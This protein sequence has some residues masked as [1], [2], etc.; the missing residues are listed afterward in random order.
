[1]KNKVAVLTS[2]TGIAL[3]LCA[4]LW[5]MQ[6][7]RQGI[8][9][10]AVL[11]LSLTAAAAGLL[12][13]LY[14]AQKERLSTVSH[15]HQ[16]ETAALE[17]QSKQALAELKAQTQR[18]ME[19][20]RSSLSHSL[21]M[22]VSIIQGYA[23]LLSSG[24]VKDEEAKQEYLKKICQRSQ[25]MTEAISRQ[26]STADTLANSSLSYSELDLISLAQQAVGDLQTAA[27]EQG[28]KIQVISPE[29]HLPMQGD[30]YLLNRVLFNLLENSLKYMGRP[31]S[32][33]IR[34]LRQKANV[35][36]LVQDDGI[37]LSSQETAHIFEP[38]YQGSNRSGGKGYGLC[39]VQRAIEGHGG[40]VCAQSAPGRGMG[41]TMTLP[42]APPTA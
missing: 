11:G 42:L 21:R 34:I 40:T 12:A 17:Q 20:F 3:L 19:S 26:F 25:Y 10:A 2:L 23:E 5:L 33:T 14:A 28:V 36:I 30:S 22:P 39:L 37:G 38:Y 9:P 1:M 32:I 41:I 27:A 29:E 31:G 15:L 6:L 24:V 8:T 13:A 7:L 16:K 18:E 4:G 35:S